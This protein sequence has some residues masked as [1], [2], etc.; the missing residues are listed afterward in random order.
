MIE[1]LAWGFVGLMAL[2]LIALGLGALLP[3]PD[4]SP[5]RPRKRMWPWRRVR[6]WLDELNGGPNQT[7]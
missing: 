6:L 3:G 4:L 1:F 7:D 5:E 2:G